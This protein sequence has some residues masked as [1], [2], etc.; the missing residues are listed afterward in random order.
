VICERATLA[1]QKLKEVWGELRL[2]WVC[3]ER[4]SA[5]GEKR[6]LQTGDRARLYPTPSRA[7][8]PH[9]QHPRKNQPDR[10][11]TAP[12]L[13]PFLAREFLV[14]SRAIQKRGM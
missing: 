7:I 5:I 9:I 11:H 14:A 4:M 10:V 3:R 12:K 2:A 13:D 8:S 1:R 6:T